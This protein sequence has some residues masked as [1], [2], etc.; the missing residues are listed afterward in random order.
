MLLYLV[1]SAPLFALILCL[2]Y[3][4]TRPG[5]SAVM[6]FH[7]MLSAVPLLALWWALGTFVELTYTPGGLYLQELT[8]RMLHPLL[9]GV[10][11]F[12]LFERRLWRERGH[13]AVIAL[14]A[15]LAGVYFV[16]SL[17]DVLRIAHHYSPYVAFLLPTLRIGLIA[18]VPA[19]I[20]ATSREPRPV[21]L[22]PAAG[23]VLLPAAFAAAALLDHLNYAPIGYLS[24]ALVVALAFLL[25][26]L[27]IGSYYPR[28]TQ[29]F[30]WNMDARDRRVSEELIPDTNET[31]ASGSDDATTRDDGAGSSPV[32]EVSGHTERDA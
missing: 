21:R 31:D 20:G 17:V 2:F 25:H 3:G 14:A 15:F 28:R 7:G 13:V 29:A 22:L 16:Q 24:I 1:L 30:S 5:P 12:F 8:L 23:I 11:L 9:P 10:G 4:V 19:L 6:F 18:T 32:T 26:A 27:L